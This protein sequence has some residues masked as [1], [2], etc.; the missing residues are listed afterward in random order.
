[1]SVKSPHILVRPEWL[2]LSVEKAIEPELPIV[3]AHHHLWDRPHGQ[4]YLFD[5]L[6]EDARAGH[7]VRGTVFVQS[8]SMYREGLPPELQ[9]VGE[10]EFANG[11]GAQ[12]AS[13][14]YGQFR[15][16]AGIVGFADLMLG[17]RLDAVLSALQQAGRDR[18]RGIRNQTAW[19][20]H[21]DINTNPVPPKPGL[22]S[23]PEF[24]AG[25]RTLARRGLTLDVW[26]YHT[27][28]GEVA[29][30]ADACRDTLIVV[31]HCGGPLGDGPYRGLRGEVFGDWA[32]QMKTL[33]ERPNLRV[34]LGGL[35]MKV[36]G[37]IFHESPKPP[38]SS[39][40]SEAWKPYILKCIELF[41]AHRCMFESNFPVDKGMVSY[42]ALWNA[43]KLI[44]KG[45]SEGERT[46]LFSGAAIETYRLDL[47]S[48]GL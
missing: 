12:A 30:L 48:M 18:F 15:A 39:A 1:M 8:R 16:C 45:F 27:Q 43:F 2:S 26:A 13:G 42:V 46:A 25:A 41:G 32:A 47:P 23:R 29:A 31:D 21:P 20:E 3:D 40:L 33:A 34:K 35:A 44:T 14:L 4:R 28:L 7:D 17:D 10:V 38:T 11:V 22:L 9:P 36:G 19:H 6:L 5:D 24:I 37:F